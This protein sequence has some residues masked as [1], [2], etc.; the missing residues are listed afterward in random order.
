[1]RTCRLHTTG[2]DVTGELCGDLQCPV[3]LELFQQPLILPCS[4]VLCRT[5]CCSNLLHFNFI[6]CPVCRVDSFIN[7]GLHSLPR[8]IVLENIIDK[9][10]GQRSRLELNVQGSHPERPQQWEVTEARTAL[11]EHLGTDIEHFNSW[12][13][14]DEGRSDS[15]AASRQAS[16]FFTS[17]TFSST[18][19]VLDTL[20]TPRDEERSVLHHLSSEAGI[21]RGAHPVQ[22]TCPPCPRPA[23]ETY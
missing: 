23:R 21:F 7:G 12:V 4:H 9:V 17:S 20:L 2:V 16:G 18:A 14:G 5:P 22:T 3:C 15:G 19:L 13:T 1:M 10:R 8:V 11:V 6:R